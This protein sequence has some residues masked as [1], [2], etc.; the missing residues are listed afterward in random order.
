MRL[1]SGPPLSATA[2]S[3]GSPVSWARPTRL[4]PLLLL[5][6]PATPQAE[7]PS[8]NPACADRSPT[9]TRWLASFDGVPLAISDRGQVR[10]AGNGC[11]R[12]WS[13]VG[14]RFRSVDAWGQVVGEAVVKSRS[15][16]DFARCYDLELKLTRGRRGVIYASSSGSWRA[17]AKAAWTPTAR[18]S[19][20]LRRFVASLDQL[21]QMSGPADKEPAAGARIVS[22]R[23][24]ERKLDFES[25]TRPNPTRF[26]VIGGRYLAIAA[27]HAGEWKLNHLDQGFTSDRRQIV[28]RPLAVFDLD[29][30][31]TPEVVIHFSE[32]EFFGDDVLR[33]DRKFLRWQRAARSV[34]GSTA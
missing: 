34:M 32:G 25:A 15:Y 33:L 20:A 31:G 5:F 4:L 11:C 9:A 6:L 2:S 8:T 10:E 24:P 21:L 23:I 28:Y 7:P 22:F 19:A 17:P 26:A 12:P 16:Y 30:D 3:R 27:L 29:G 13:R 14:G 1:H 18:E